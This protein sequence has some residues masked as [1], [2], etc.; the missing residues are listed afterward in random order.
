MEVFRQYRSILKVFTA[1]TCIVE[2]FL[3]WQLKP[4]NLVIVTVLFGI[5]GFMA[6][7]IVAVT[8]EAAAECTYP[9]NEELSSALLMTS[10]SVF[11]IIYIS[12]W[13]S[14]LPGDGHQYDNQW[15]FSTYFLVINAAVMLI[16]MSLFRGEYNRLNAEAHF[17]KYIEELDDTSIAESETWN[18]KQAQN[19]KRQQLNENTVSDNNNGYQII[20]DST[21]VNKPISVNKRGNAGPAYANGSADNSLD[22]PINY[23]QDV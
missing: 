6:I 7:P 20:N 22:K 8:F 21:I 3:L 18:Q 12:I 11:G 16:F 2:L 17:T 13:G 5:F 10:G 4:N 14:Q 9:A 19:V 1:S 15:N 23:D